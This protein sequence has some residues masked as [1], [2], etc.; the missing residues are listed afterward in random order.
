MAGRTRVE[1]LSTDGSTVLDVESG[2]D[3]SFEQAPDSTLKF[4][5]RNVSIADGTA[6]DSGNG[7]LD[8]RHGDQLRVIYADE[9]VDG[10]GG[11]PDKVRVALAGID[12]RPRLLTG[13]SRFSQF[14]TNTTHT[15]HFLYHHAGLSQHTDTGTYVH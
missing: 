11:D 2:D 4:V 8:V 1:V 15:E 10:E 12:C 14:G 7:V 5:A 6:Y 9:S 13:A 3:L